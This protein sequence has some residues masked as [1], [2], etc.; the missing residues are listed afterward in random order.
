MG[1]GASTG[2]KRFRSVWELQAELDKRMIETYIMEETDR[3]EKGSNLIDKP[4]G[5]RPVP[6]LASSH[7]DRMNADPLT[8]VQYYIKQKTA[9]RQDKVS[10]LRG[11]QQVHTP[12]AMYPRPAQQVV[13][14]CIREATARRQD[15]GCTLTGK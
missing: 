7:T 6:Q 9:H 13:E 8:K 1:S 2:P 15:K 14:N 11:R 4:K 5:H 10:N 3:Q 12:A